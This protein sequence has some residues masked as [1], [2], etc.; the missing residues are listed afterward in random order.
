M[1]NPET[2]RNYAV[3]AERQEMIVQYIRA[4]G[5][6]QIHALGEWL[7]VSDATIRRDLDDLDQVGKLE[8]THGGAICSRCGTAFE[9]RH[10]EKMHIMQEEKRR[11]AQ[12]AASDIR[13][14]DTI[15]LDSGTTTYFLGTFLRDIPNLTVFTYDLFIAYSLEL[16][17]TSSLVVTGGVR[18]QGY[19][20]VLLGAQVENFLQGLRVDKAF[21]GADAVDLDYG[22]SNSNFMEAEIKRQ[23]TRS[24]LQT[25]LLVDHGK[26]NTVALARVCALGDIDVLITDSGAD[27]E[28]Q[29]ALKKEIGRVDAV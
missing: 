14:G 20:N 23:A 26:F 29:E 12:R 16:H 1:G 8:R 5:S 25:Y 28:Y 6:A 9:R 21:L 19:P 3:P 24:G 17:P 13:E 22:V 7:G 27:A 10:D 4:N 2:K 11:I 15:F 18:R